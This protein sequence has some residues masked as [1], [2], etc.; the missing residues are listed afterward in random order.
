[1]M[2]KIAVFLVVCVMLLGVLA[3][4]VSGEHEDAEASSGRSRGAARSNTLYVGLH[5]T[6]DQIQSAI[7]N[8]TDGDTIRVYDGTYYE[9]VV[10]DRIL[11]IIGNGTTTTTINGTFTGST[12]TILADWC[13]VSGFHITASKHYPF[14]AGGIKLLGVENCSIKDC[15][16]TE[17]EIGIL[18]EYSNKTNI[19]NCTGKSN[20]WDFI[21]LTWSKNNY[22]ANC[23]SFWNPVG[24]D[25]TESDL[26]YFEF[27]NLIHTSQGARLS[28]S[29]KNRFVFNTFKKNYYHAITLGSY[30]CNQNT[31]CYNNFVA[32]NQGGT[33]AKDSGNNRWNASTSKKGNYW[34][35]WISPDSDSDGIVDLPYNID[36]SASAEDRWP[37]VKPTRFVGRA[38]VITTTDVKEAY[39]DEYYSNQYFATDPDTPGYNLIWDMK[40][41]ASWLNFGTIRELNGTPTNSDIGTYW[42]N[43]SVRDETN[44]VFHNFTLTVMKWL[45]GKGTVVI[46]RT[47]QKFNKIQDAIDNAT[48]GDTIRIWSGIYHENLEV[49]KTL[50]LIGNGTEN[51]VINFTSTKSLITVKADYCI[52]TNLSVTGGQPEGGN[53]SN[54]GAGIHILND[55]TKIEKCEIFEN[56]HGILL[57][58]SDHN[59]ILECN[60][61]K[62]LVYGIEMSE[63]NKNEI[64]NCTIFGNNEVGLHLWLSD[65]NSIIFCN[66]SNNGQYGFYFGDSKFNSLDH[67]LMVSNNYNGVYISDKAGNNIITNNNI[68]EHQ[69]LGIFIDYGCNNNLIHHNN[70]IGNSWNIDNTG[71]QAGDMGAASRWNTSTEGNFW[72]DY[73][74][75]FP[76]ATNNGKVWDTPY[77]IDGGA[78][79]HYPLVAPPF[80]SALP[81]VIMTQNILTAYAGQLYSVNY[82]ATDPDTPQSNLTWTMNTNASWLIFSTEQELVGTPKDSDVG[83]YW[84]YIAVTDGKYMDSTNFT[85]TVIKII[86]PPA[87]KNG[88][89]INVRTGKRY[90]RIQDAID[91]ASYRDTIKVYSGT[92]NE[93]VVINKALTIIGNSST[94]TI[95][96]GTK[97]GPV[98]TINGHRCNIAGLRMKHN[99]PSGYINSGILTKGE[100]NYISDCDLSDNS[101]GVLFESSH[102]IIFNCTLSVN[103]YEG[104]SI[105]NNSM[106]NTISYN[107]IID[108]DGLAVRIDYSSS[109]NNLHHN[110][111]INNLVG[112]IHYNIQ[113]D[114]DGSNNKWNTT[115]EGNYW[116]DWTKP[117]NNT[118]GIVDNPY[119]LGGSS[120]AKDYYPLTRMVGKAPPVPHPTL[121]PPVI[122]TQNVLT[123]HVGTRYSVN[124]TATDPDTPVSKLTW[125]MTTNA[126][127]L[128]F[129]STQELFGTPNSSDKGTYWVYIGVTDGNL[130][131]FTN[132]TLTVLA[133][134]QTQNKTKPEVKYT[135]ID[136]NRYNVSVNTSEIIITFSHPMN[137]SSVEASLTIK[138]W[139]N[140]TLVWLNDSVLKIVFSENLSYNTTYTI[141]FG[142]GAKDIEGNDLDSPF[143]LIFTTE[144]QQDEGDGNPGHPDGDGMNRVSVLIIILVTT[145]ILIFL[146]VLSF[147]IK[148]RSK[149]RDELEKST[150]ESGEITVTNGID[151][152]I[153]E[154]KKE[155]MVSNKPSNFGPSKDELLSKFEKKYRKGKISKNT[156]EMIRESLSERKP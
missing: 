52:I 34:S 4:P 98:M 120:G 147:V 122:T 85:L 72:S 102:N 133:K 54:G 106:N 39:V 146:I 129:S 124:Y 53:S 156:F 113:A 126:S 79:D 28:F 117:D 15:N 121:K 58:S 51:T 93:N 148:N 114:D 46:V 110:N 140:Y 65:N 74:S 60:I 70:F 2:R 42:V 29:S 115:K 23:S 9:N 69:G 67:N 97:I 8:A 33:Q 50:T 38:P 76:N 139:N 142:T 66:S 119:V 45:P 118:D 35:D 83:T 130:S 145:I 19:Q 24:F 112:L 22:I 90:Y 155:A 3:L 136:Y 16:F 94:D 131:D 141:S 20:S 154:L 104:I 6:Y 149:R 44:I 111:F 82:T 18:L 135:N 101:R 89:V 92:Y 153:F 5:Q 88:T 100:Y 108:N 144:V 134:K 1:M 7:N 32:N 103:T 109:N 17:N 61:Y 84:V 99:N 143:E 57:H 14:N 96:T 41:N 10:V 132:F 62:N 36:G 87:P 138:P 13:N 71:I 107:T 30:K 81:P 123:A 128:A 105:R 26:N 12:I 150:E 43:I 91:N 68:V 49:D 40:T 80:P 151:E 78:Q 31:I 116:S 95:V 152:V 11:S 137:R 59:E 56:Y 37:L 63:A 25:L 47:G 127:W 64:K 73:I 21:N 48:S 75:R 55:H 27:N 77:N 86:T 125:S